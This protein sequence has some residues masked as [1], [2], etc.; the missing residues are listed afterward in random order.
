MTQV[1]DGGGWRALGC[2]ETNKDDDAVIS[3][4]HDVPDAILVQ[5][6]DKEVGGTVF[7]ASAIF[8]SLT[9]FS[10]ARHITCEIMDR[11][12]D[13]SESVRNLHDTAQ[14]HRDGTL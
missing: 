12:A 4:R 2:V 11:G 13:P 7:M 5:F 3:F 9:R 1:D 6:S 14:A 10:D 8:P